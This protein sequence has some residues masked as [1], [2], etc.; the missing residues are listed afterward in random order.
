VLFDDGDTLELE[1][2]PETVL[3]WSCSQSPFEHPD[4]LAFLSTVAASYKPDLVVMHGDEADL[5][6]AKFQKADSM[7]PIAE[8]EH[9]KRFVRDV[10]KIF[11]CMLLL[12]S[13][14][15]HS[16]LK[17]A[18]A[19]ANIP[20]MMMKDWPSLIEAPPDWTWR[21][22]IIARNWL[23]EHGHDIS[24][25]A[26]GSIIEETINRFGRPLS[27]MRGHHHGLHG[28]FMRPIWVSPTQQVRMFYVG[29]LMAKRHVSYTRAPL[30]NGAAITYRGHPLAIPM[31][32]D[33]HDRWTGRLAEW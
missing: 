24:R 9:V 2:L 13:N 25:G 28:D 8:L 18:Q 32:K 27:I 19:K 33:R 17:G 23:W 31:E 26:R 6:F 1:R 5:E 10:A 14:H 20:T 15:I 7:S 30:I 22:Y 16:R 11:P 29:C 3:H 12:T 4:S 21:S